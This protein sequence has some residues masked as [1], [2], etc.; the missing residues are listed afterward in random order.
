MR[1]SQA[2]TKGGESFDNTDQKPTEKE[3][4]E[5]IHQRE[6][7][8]YY[9]GGIDLLHPLGTENQEHDHQGHRQ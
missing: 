2:G 4:S 3:G 5:A 8:T 7:K 1:P 6:R 9:P